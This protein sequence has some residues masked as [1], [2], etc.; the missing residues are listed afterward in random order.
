MSLMIVVCRSRLVQPQIVQNAPLLSV[1]VVGHELQA[2]LFV[3][4]L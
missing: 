2:L 3:R 1:C 4:L